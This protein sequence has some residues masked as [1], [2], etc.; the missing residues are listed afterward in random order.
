ML[1]VSRILRLIGKLKGL[2]ALIQTIIFSLP[3]LSSVFSLLMLVFFIYSIL[4]VFLFK[5][6]KSGNIIDPVYMNFNNFSNAMIL[7]LRVSTGEDWN[8]IMYDCM[9]ESKVA[10]FYFI[11]FILICTYVM[12]NLF[13]LVIL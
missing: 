11:S 7:L 1:R 4:G 6:I 10:P 8:R 2:Q 12:L 5:D 13:V 9:K 3:P